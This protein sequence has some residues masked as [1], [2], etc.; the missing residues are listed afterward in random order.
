MKNTIATAVFSISLLFVHPAYAQE[1]AKPAASPASAESAAAPADAEERFKALLT[2]A[3]LSGRWAPLKDG[4]LGE[5]KS[6]D[7][8]HIVSATKSN[9][10][11][12]IISAKLKY[13]DQEFVMPIPVQMKF[14]GDTAIM[15][16]DKLAI[17][18]GGTYSARLL[19]YE[20]TYSGTWSGAHGGGML[21]GVITNGASKE[22]KS[23]PKEKQQ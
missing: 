23:P 4:Q 15:V 2:D 5:E 20:R 3:F 10:D 17:P 11:N 7:K 21:Y 13:H 14:A 12:W 6:G 16:V 9:G 8:Y 18:N 22:D 1:K 19:F